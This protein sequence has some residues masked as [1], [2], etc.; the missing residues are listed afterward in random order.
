MGMSAKQK[1]TKLVDRFFLCVNLGA[2]KQFISVER[3][4]YIVTAAFTVNKKGGADSC[5]WQLHDGIAK[6]RRNYGQTTINTGPWAMFRRALEEVWTKHGH[7]TAL[8]HVVSL[9]CY[10]LKTL[11]PRFR[12]H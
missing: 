11:S 9:A 7:N 12:E 1:K 5:S 3:K 2:T 10:V 8:R 6:I 4:G